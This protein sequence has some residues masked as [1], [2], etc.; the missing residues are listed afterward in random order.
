MLSR[1]SELKLPSRS[2][3]Y[4]RGYLGVVLLIALR[5]A[6]CENNVFT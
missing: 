5:V 1:R 6:A 3:I 4:W 2:T